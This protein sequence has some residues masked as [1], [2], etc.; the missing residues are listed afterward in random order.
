M[1][2]EFQSPCYVQGHQ[3][4]DQA[5]QSHIQPQLLIFHDVIELTGCALRSQAFVVLFFYFW[6]AE[7]LAL[8]LTGSSCESV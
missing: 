1:I 5:A 7:F 3:P 2:I 4:P 6:W 8:P